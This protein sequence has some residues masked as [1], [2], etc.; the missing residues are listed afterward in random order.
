MKHRLHLHTIVSRFIEATQ[1]QHP[2]TPAQWKVMRHLTQC[3]TPALGG[4]F[5]QCGECGFSQHRYHSCRNRHCPQCQHRATVQWCERQR[6]HTLPV[7][8][9]HVV[10]TLPDTLNPWVA[11]HAAVIYRCL[12]AS[13]WHT[14]K[15]F[16]ADA[17]RLHG[18]MGMSA[19]LH[20]WGQSLIRHVHLHCLIPGGAFT[21]D[22]QWA[23]AKSTYLFPVR[24][25]S[26]HFRGAMVSALRKA[27]TRGELSLLSHERV[28]ADL[29]QLMRKDWVVYSKAYLK[30]ADSVVN[31]LGRYTH[32]IAISESRLRAVTDEQVVFDVKDYRT[33]TTQPMQLDGV[34]FLRRFLLHVLPEGFMRVRHYGFLANR[35]R[36]VKL[37][38]IRERLNTANDHH[39]AD[40]TRNA[41]SDVRSTASP[42]CPCPKCR[43]GFLRVRYDIAPQPL[44]RR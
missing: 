7:T 4:Q 27:H 30:Q 41:E 24:A 42:A 38:R 37:A 15:T 32:R 35:T 22:G 10:F 20:T 18:E 23:A 34:E 40:N 39:C 19:V 43:T 21:A 28:N 1:Q 44:T 8:Y 14:I 29:N 5:V 6:R 16:G 31:Y 2:L 26:R 25:L 17:K 13:V 36:A 33:G 12:F 9:Y 11:C 3:R